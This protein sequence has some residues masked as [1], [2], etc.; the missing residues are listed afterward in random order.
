MSHSSSSTLARSIPTS[1]PPQDV[2]VED[3]LLN[4]AT[5]CYISVSLR[6]HFKSH[7]ISNHRISKDLNWIELPPVLLH[8]SWIA[9]SYVMMWH[10]DWSGRGWGT[11]IIVTDSPCLYVYPAADCLQAKAFTNARHLS[12]FYAIVEICDTSSMLHLRLSWNM[13]QLR[14]LI[15]R[16]IARVS[17]SLKRWFGDW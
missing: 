2:T 11:Y 14:R 8:V 4:I 12:N 10:C 15:D 9:N 1:K 5:K 3:V 16:W 7:F 13:T 6:H 17:V